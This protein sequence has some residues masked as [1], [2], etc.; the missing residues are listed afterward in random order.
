LIEKG[1]TMKKP[2][3]VLL[4]V[5][6]IPISA[7]VC[8]ARDPECGQH[9]RVGNL[10]SYNLNDATHH[11]SARNGN[12]RFHNFSLQICHDTT[13]VGNM[14]FNDSD[15]GTRGASGEI[16]GMILYNLDW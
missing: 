11:S 6:F 9:Q 3:L 2:F 12:M 7:N 1:A 10:V 4:A 13:E 5:L 15:D 14:Q 8:Q 16:G